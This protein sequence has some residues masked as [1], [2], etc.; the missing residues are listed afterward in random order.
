VR[1]A[2]REA[3]NKAYA[4]RGMVRDPDPY[5]ETLGTVKGLGALLV[6]AFGIVMVAK[7]LWWK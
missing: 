4:E 2:H 1:K 6:V 3:T 7:F 5:T